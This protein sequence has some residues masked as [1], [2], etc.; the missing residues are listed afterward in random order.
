MNVDDLLLQL[1]IVVEKPNASELG[2]KSALEDLLVWLNDTANNTD[3]NCR[4]VDT[5]VATGISIEARVKL[6]PQVQDL[7]F[8]VGGQLHDTH[9]APSVARNFESTPEQLLARVRALHA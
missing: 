3:E 1:K 2:V 4:K 9:S 7:L 8:D 5:F 6:S